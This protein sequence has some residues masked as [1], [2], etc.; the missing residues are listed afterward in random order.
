MKRAITFDY[1]QTL[2]DDTRERETMTAR[3]KM[4][5]EYLSA[6]G[7]NPPESLD[8]GFAAAK[9][10][11]HGIYHGDQRTPTL[12]ER[13]EFVLN[14]YDIKLAPIQLEPLAQKFGELGLMLS[15]V[16]T[17][18]IAETL[19]LLSKSYP[20]GIVSD[21]GY[22]PGSVLRKH[23]ENHDLLQYFSAF[24]FSN[25]S[26][27]AKPHEHAF[28]TALN[29]LGVEPSNAIHCGDMLEHDVLGAKKLGMTAV[30]YK[31]CW[32]SETDGIIP[33]YMIADWQELPAIVEEVFA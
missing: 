17:P 28:M 20:L 3:K 15:P 25:E 2:V 26:G 4:M 33:D 32:A 13:L 6:N 23:L 7:F 16:P 24:S 19:A 27:R 18:N 14:H 1:W 5:H 11:F 10:W 21:T 9:P 31:G 8:A 29:Q 12:E 22:T 30:L